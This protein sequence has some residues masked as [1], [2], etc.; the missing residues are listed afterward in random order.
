MGRLV[1]L[2]PEGGVYYMYADT[3][4]GTGNAV[5]IISS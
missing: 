4:R 3:R 1:P 2:Q 5:L